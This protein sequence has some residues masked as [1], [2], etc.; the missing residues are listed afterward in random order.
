M[1]NIIATIGI[2]KE[3]TRWMG[4]LGMLNI[5]ATIDH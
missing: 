2:I 4:L 1:L 3:K 5:I